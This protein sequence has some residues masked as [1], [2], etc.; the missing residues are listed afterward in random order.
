MKLKWRLLGRDS[1]MHELLTSPTLRVSSVR[2]GVVASLL[3]LTYYS[4]VWQELVFGLSSHVNT[5][6]CGGMS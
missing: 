4:S 1:L 2:G 6:T 5:A 3:P